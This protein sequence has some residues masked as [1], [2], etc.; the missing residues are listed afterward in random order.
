MESNH[1]QNVFKN[2][3]SELVYAFIEGRKV[4]SSVTR[5]GEISPLWQN[6]IGIWQKFKPILAIFK[7]D[8]GQMF[9]VVKGQILKNDRAIWSH[10]Y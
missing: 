8:I 3:I 1:R 4:G 6:V 2:S 5:F 9:T 7:I 10:W